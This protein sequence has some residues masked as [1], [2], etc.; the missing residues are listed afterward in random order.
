MNRSRVNLICL[1]ALLLALSAPSAASAADWSF[2]ISAYWP[3]NEGKGQTVRDWSGKGNNG[4]LG[5]TAGV[6]ANDPT[7]IR[8]IYGWSY[9]L[10]FDGSDFVSIPD[11]AS[12]RPAQVTVSAWFRGDTTPGP[13]RYLVAK[14]SNQCDS[15]S[16]GLYSS[17]NSG[18]AFYVSDGTNNFARSPEADPSV[19]DGRSHNAAGTFDGQTVRLFIDGVEVGSGTPRTEPIGYA[20]PDG[21]PPRHLRRELRP[22]ADRRSRRS[23]H[24]VEGAPDRRH[25]AAG[26]DPAL[27]SLSLPR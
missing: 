18:L 20:L 3:L 2:P 11:S 22:H 9:G 23:Q 15:A 16:Y 27:A 26:T 1:G 13:N 7:W 6:D 25:L 12:L 5:S 21:S 17:N 10:H 19:W 24:L 14:G 4:R 8:G